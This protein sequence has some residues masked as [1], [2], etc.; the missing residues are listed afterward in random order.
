ML[1]RH[2]GK[3]WQGKNGDQAGG[4]RQHDGKRNITPGQKHKQVRRGTS[5]AGRDDH[6]TN[7]NGRRHTEQISQPE[8]HHRHQE[9]LGEGAHNHALRIHRHL[10]KIPQ[11]KRHT[12]TDHDN[13]QCDRQTCRDQRAGF[14]KASEYSCC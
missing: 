7:G 6:Q 4:D 9:N 1:Q 5:R 11:G 14:H 12:D 13:E 2:V 8:R 3:Q 10:A